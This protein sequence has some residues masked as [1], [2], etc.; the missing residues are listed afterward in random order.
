MIFV[1][2]RRHTTSKLRV[3]RLQETNFASYEESTGCPVRGLLLL[4]H[5]AADL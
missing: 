4:S 5:L 2:V 3:F 1:L